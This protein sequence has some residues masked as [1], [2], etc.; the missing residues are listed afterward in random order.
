[1]KP[2]RPCPALIP[3]V[4][5]LA[6]AATAGCVDVPSPPT[7][8]DPADASDGP[9]PDARFGDMDPDAAFDDMDPDRD[10]PDARIADAGDTRLDAGGDIADLAPPDQ[11]LPDMTP[12]DMAP[13]DM[14]LPIDM[15]LPDV[16]PPDQGI[17]EGPLRFSDCLPLARD[18]LPEPPE[19][20]VPCVQFAEAMPMP[21]RLSW[22]E[23]VQLSDGRV[24]LVGGLRSEGQAG[25]ASARIDIY[26]PRTDTWSA[27]PPLPSGRW[28]HTAAVIDLGGEEAIVVI[29]GAGDTGDEGWMPLDEVLSWTRNTRRWSP[30][31]QGASPA[32]AQ[33]ASWSDGAAVWFFGG[34]T[35]P[36][37]VLS[38]AVSTWSERGGPEP[39]GVLTEARYG[40]TVVGFRGM[41]IVI[42]GATADQVAV[43]SAE[44]PVA[45][46]WERLG[47]DALQRAYPAAAVFADDRIIVAGGRS[48]GLDAN[49]QGIMLSRLATSAIIEQIAGQGWQVR[50]GPSMNRPRVF[51][52]VAPIDDDRYLLAV[53]GEPIDNRPVVVELYDGTSWLPFRLPPSADFIRN[54]HT[55]VALDDGRVLV[56]GGVW[57]DAPAGSD[58]LFMN[59]T[60]VFRIGGRDVAIVP[61]GTP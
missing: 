30:L 27:G 51:F 54:H 12:V 34:T 59:Q 43:N 7:S 39:E 13:G 1:M 25:V 36:R 6:A 56:A 35:A 44:Y 15:A 18:E 33:G 58:E 8:G 53:G 10:P 17:V 16:G 45:N 55:V 23:G 4:A 22:R 42:G 61:D 50:E 20:L 46:G 37:G 28:A 48:H 47:S 24:A 41:P 2:I 57:G 40:H 9:P 32:V 21:E 31:G 52:G 26:D 49:G 29:G 38:R 5:L 11:A 60:L 3:L 19:Q 14:A